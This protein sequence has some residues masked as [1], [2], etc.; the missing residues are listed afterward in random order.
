MPTQPACL[1][2]VK[3]R[4]NLPPDELEARYH[5]RM[6]AFR[7]QSGLLQKYYVRYAETDEWGGLYLWDS[8]ESMQRYLAS[9]L[10]QSIPG[11]YE[12]VGEPRVEAGAVVDVLRSD[13][14]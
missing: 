8:R 12:V 4:S 3:F 5:E 14:R 1:L 9:D 13:R 11:V 6:P 10:R 2:L 7:E